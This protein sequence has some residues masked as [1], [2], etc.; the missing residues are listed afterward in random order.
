M[1]LD[2]GAPLPVVDEGSCCAPVGAPPLDAA[3]AAELAVLLR[4]LA[5]PMRLQL[6][7]L[8][9]AS[10]SACICDLTDPVGLSQPTVSHHMRV[11]VE[12]GLLSREKRGRWVHFSVIPDALGG[13]SVRLSDLVTPQPASQLLVLGNH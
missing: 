8:V 3:D 7:S 6:L 13:L 1:T 2:V 4:A 10:G 12:A 11:L 9:V 5:D